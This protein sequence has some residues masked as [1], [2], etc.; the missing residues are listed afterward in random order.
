MFQKLFLLCNL[1][2]LCFYRA[3]G[4][5]STRKRTATS[6]RT[7]T[8]TT[9]T[10]ATASR[11]SRGRTAT[12]PA[13]ASSTRTATP[14]L[15]GRTSK[16]GRGRRRPSPDSPPQ[17]VG[18]DKKSVSNNSQLIYHHIGHVRKLFM[19]IICAFFFFLNFFCASLCFGCVVRRRWENDLC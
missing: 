17:K 11:K 1:T 8:T 3:I 16:W 12:A 6:A 13:A 19:K 4:A 7:V 2:F 10:T 15:G 14:R 9:V 18:V 5:A